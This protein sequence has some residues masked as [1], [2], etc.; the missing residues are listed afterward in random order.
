MVE[1][2]VDNYLLVEVIMWGVLA[3]YWWFSALCASSRRR[4]VEP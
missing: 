3:L 4:R 1:A 2:I